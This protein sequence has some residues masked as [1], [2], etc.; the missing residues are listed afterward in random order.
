[1][2]FFVATVLRLFVTLALL[3][4]VLVKAAVAISLTVVLAHRHVTFLIDHLAV[5][6]LFRQSSH[7]VFSTLSLLVLLSGC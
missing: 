7:L 1:M 3:L 2:S 6:A 5:Q 4:Q